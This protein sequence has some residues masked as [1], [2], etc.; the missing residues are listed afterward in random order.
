MLPQMPATDQV[1]AIAIQ[2]ELMSGESIVW[3]GQPQRSVIFHKEDSFLI[4]FSLLWGGFAIFWEAGA[5]GSWGKHSNGQWLFALWGIPFV[6]IGQYLIWSRFVYAAWLKR[7]T[8]YAVTN[9]RVLVIQDGWKRQVASAYVDSLPSLTKEGATNGIGILR[10]GPE[11]NMWSNNRGW[12]GRNALSITD[13]PTSVDIDDVDSV[14]RLVSDL[15]E[16]SRAS[17]PT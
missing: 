17:K 6:V 15:R 14:Y 3:A 5:S 12:Q 10:F 7:R 11:P 16:R 4:P 1:A 13:L 8:Y 9:R 2:P